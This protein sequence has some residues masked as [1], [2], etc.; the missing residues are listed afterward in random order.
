ML[1]STRALSVLLSIMYATFV[2][3]SENDNHID[4]D[5]RFISALYYSDWSY[6]K[7]LPSDI[8][9]SRITHL[10]Y[11]F[12]G[13][14]A[15]TAN[16][17]FDSTSDLNANIPFGKEILN[18]D[19]TDLTYLNVSNNVNS[20]FYQSIPWMEKYLNNLEHI[21][22]NASCGLIGQLR[23][24]REINPR[25]KIS[26]AIGGANSGKLF[27]AITRSNKHMKQFAANIAANVEALGFDGVDFD[28]EFPGSPDDGS[29]LNNIVEKLRTLFKKRNKNNAKL[30]TV[31]IP[32][33]RDVL[34]YYNL[35]QLEKNVDYFNLMGY[36]ISGKWSQV[37]SFHSQLY[38]DTNI[39]ASSISVNNAVEYISAQVNS[40]KIILGMPTYGISFNAAALYEKFDGCAKIRIDSED[41]DTEEDYKE[42]CII[43]YINLPPGGYVEVEDTEIGASYAY[44]KNK[45]KGLVVYDTPKIAR[46][47]ARYVL[48]K[49]L[50]GGMWWDSKG[51]PLLKNPSRSLVYNFVDELGGIYML[52][53]NIS[54][55]DAY[56]VTQNSIVTAE[57]DD[58]TFVISSSRRKSVDKLSVVYIIVMY[59]FIWC[60]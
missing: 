48:D 40:S 37:S 2:L 52:V 59:L 11:A 4:S 33:D 9:L 30:I 39:L 23:Q 18:D 46:L 20:A 28:W 19:F 12:A 14:D 10:Y 1:L 51:D 54:D 36:D 26:L 24:M 60:L 25:L 31:A 3:S 17:Q 27:K 38:T 7:Q 42:E 34:K 35:A 13:I 50:A 16:I 58:V 44:N 5:R 41:E 22:L 6:E 32:L 47:K 45:K 43:D 49:G 53:S 56:S 8:P 57:V 21:N 55:L 29:A 15:G